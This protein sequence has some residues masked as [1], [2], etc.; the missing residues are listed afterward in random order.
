MMG[1][2]IV[3]K[4]SCAIRNGNVTVFNDSDRE[5]ECKNGSTAYILPLPFY[6]RMIPSC[7][8][9]S[10]CV[11]DARQ[12]LESKI[13]TNL[14]GVCVKQEVRHDHATTTYLSV[15]HTISIAAEK[16]ERMHDSIA[17]AKMCK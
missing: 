11:S 12:F 1:D 8:R 6:I 17:D 15:D 4:L 7:L 13:D 10:L 16:L 9:N 3:P 2:I 14:Y 5:I